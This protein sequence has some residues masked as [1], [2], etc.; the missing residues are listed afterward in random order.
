LPFKPLIPDDRDES[1]EMGMAETLI[2]RLSNLRQ[3]IV[4]PMSAV[5]TYTAVEQDPVAAGR[6][7]RVDAVLDGDV[8]K[9]GNRVRITVHLVRVSDGHTLW[10]GKFDERLVDIF[11]LEDSIS[12]RVAAVMAIK[13]T[14]EERELLT[15]HPTENTEA[16]Q[17]YLKGRL[18]Y[19]Q[20]TQESIQKA[21]ECFDKAVALDTNYALAYAGKADV[22][23]A[24]SSMFLPPA[25][26]MPKAREAAEKA[27]S[28]DDQL[29][30]AHHS[31]AMVKMWADWDWSAAESEFRRALEIHPNDAQLHAHYG[32]F[33]VDQKRFDEAFG[34]LERAR[35]L[36]PLSFSVTYTLGKTLYLAR[37]YDQAIVQ[38]QEVVALYPNRFQGHRG[39]GC[40][41]RQKGMYEE[42]IA[43]LQRAVDLQPLDSCVSELGN[44]F[45][46][47][48]RRNEAIKLAEK[49]EA[50]AKVR[51]VSPV[52]IARIYAGLGAKELAF[53]W[54]HKAYRD[55]SD[56][57]LKLGVDPSFD[58]V[59]SD[60]RFSDL[61]RRVGLEQ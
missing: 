12:E 42:A 55:H 22:Y 10:T 34:E 52:D 27:L 30:E 29:S 8:Q 35:E 25:E 43:Q 11:A 32:S 1:L 50:T 44:A 53:D 3:V 24:N 15:R 40:V 38:Y 14:G 59:R 26:A 19:Q 13:L 5:R 23:S 21:L 2:T 41:L 56:H 57:L 18:Y 16:Y 61:L 39:L 51:Y 48:A 9:T 60:P 33:I 31:M 47:G 20:W 54:L 46:S 17:L 37:R 49:L 28:I 4:R 45:G 58:S 7:Q 36:D 6:E